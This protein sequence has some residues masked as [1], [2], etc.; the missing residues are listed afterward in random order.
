MKEEYDK[1][2]K[3]WMS[4]PETP[5]EALEQLETFFRVDMWYAKRAEWKKEKDML[6]YLK[7][8]FDICR[9]QI[10][11]VEKEINEIN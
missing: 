1:K 3:T 5:L 10:K 2:F 7:A 8:H 9:K 4:V 11:K 6:K